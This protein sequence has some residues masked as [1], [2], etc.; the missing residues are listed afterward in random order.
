MSEIL[1]TQNKD[2]A[3]ANLSMLRYLS[4]SIAYANF[5]TPKVELIWE[6]ALNHE[7]TGFLAKI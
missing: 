1:S 4:K 2:A 5:S 6:T 3:Y 7:S